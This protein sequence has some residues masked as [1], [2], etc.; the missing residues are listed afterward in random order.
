MGGVR[1]KNRLLPYG[2]QSICT[3][4]AEGIATQKSNKARA[5]LYAF[6]YP[7]CRNMAHPRAL[8][9]RPCP[10]KTCRGQL[11]THKAPTC[12][13]FRHPYRSQRVLLVAAPCT[14]SGALAVAPCTES[15]SPWPT[16]PTSS[17]LKLV[18]GAKCFVNLDLPYP[19]TTIFTPVSVHVCCKCPCV[20]CAFMFRCTH[21]HA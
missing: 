5:F 3:G 11:S 14:E 9:Q 15:S 19:M 1:L 6:P 16:P 8:S 18:S 4:G 2:K 20:L 7:S 13:P 10:R 12:S 17:C 21:M